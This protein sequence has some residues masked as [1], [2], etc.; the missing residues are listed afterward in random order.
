MNIDSYTNWYTTDNNALNI[1]DSILT[2]I[3]QLPYSD[4]I[5]VDAQWQHNLPGIAQQY[6]GSM[7]KWWAILMYNG[8]YDPIDDVVPGVVLKIPDKASLDSLLNA[9]QTN[10]NQQFI[11]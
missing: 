6:L 11:L 4:I 1:W 9:T 7:Y 5:Q 2:N 8:L 10:A 3:K